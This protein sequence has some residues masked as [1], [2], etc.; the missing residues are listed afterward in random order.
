VAGFDPEFAVAPTRSGFQHSAGRQ[1]EPRELG[2][3]LAGFDK[4]A[5]QYEQF[6]TPGKRL[7]DIDARRP[8][9][10][11]NKFPG[12]LVQQ[13]KFDSEEVR[14]EREREAGRID[15]YRQSFTNSVH[16]GSEPGVWRVVGRV[17][18]WRGSGRPSMSVS[19]PFVWRCLSGSAHGSVSTPRSF[20]PDMQISRIRL[21][22]KS[23]RVR[24]RLA[25]PT[26]G[27]TRPGAV[28][29]RAR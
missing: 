3:L 13:C 16:P 24:P 28:G 8:A 11:K 4:A 12:A 2:E 15:A 26:R 6:N 1:P 14:R 7:D 25:A 21:S 9:L 20:E 18:M 10:K 22:D 19:A 5:V 27:R 17:E 23:S 29:N